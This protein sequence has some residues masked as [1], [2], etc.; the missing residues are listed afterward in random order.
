MSQ[1]TINMIGNLTTAL[2]PWWKV[3]TL[4]AYFIG[5][6]LVIIGLIKFGNQ[7]QGMTASGIEIRIPLL[8]II[9]GI[10]LLNLMPLLD[11]ISVSTFGSNSISEL[12]YSPGSGVGT[13]Q[14]VMLKFA[15][16]VTQLVG[17]A[18][19][20]KGIYGLYSSSH[21]PRGFWPAISHIFGGFLALN[22]EQFIRALGATA[23]GSIQETI[24]KL[25]GS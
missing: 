22:I 21:D 1:D 18:S 4:A 16:Y 23:G 10:L 24:S 6:G 12:S 3:V 11:A 17:F 25:V 8:A 19:V 13:N 20:I 9:V 5:F 15:I 14:A 2:G 7:K